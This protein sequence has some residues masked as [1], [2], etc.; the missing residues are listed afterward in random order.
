MCFAV[1]AGICNGVFLV[2]I[3]PRLAPCARSFGEPLGEAF[4]TL[5]MFLR[6]F[7]VVLHCIGSVTRLTSREYAATSAW[8]ELSDGFLNLTARA[9]FHHS[10]RSIH[11]SA[12]E[13]ACAWVLRCTLQAA[14]NVTA[15]KAIG[16]MPTC[17]P[18]LVL[19]VTERGQGLGN[20]ATF[21]RPHDTIIPRFV[22]V[23][24]A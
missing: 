22:G 2:C 8:G 3:F 23:V 4:R 21:T 11:V 15:L 20:A 6:R 19:A 17:T 13:R 24:G 1:L 5:S 7:R 18:A 9:S 12:I 10:A 14:H 16:V